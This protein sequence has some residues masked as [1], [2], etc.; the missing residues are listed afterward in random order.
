MKIR[1]TAVII[2]NGEIL[3]L[4]QNVDKKRSWSLPGGKLEESETIE[5]GLKREL[6]EETG[7]KIRLG[8]LLYVCDH[9]HN[10][11]FVLHITLRAKCVG[12]KFG[13]TIEGLDTNAI[14]G[15]EFVP[16]KD[17]QSKGFSAK[18]QQLAEDDFPGSG[19]YMGSKSAIG[20]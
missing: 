1:L 15:M 6:F 18:F 7:L 2:E 11:E 16:I 5:Q 4:D 12:G 9:S 19:S 8:K 13:N 20:L 3:L 17:L 14:R 10:G